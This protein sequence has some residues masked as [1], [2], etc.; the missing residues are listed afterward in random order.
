MAKIHTRYDFSLVQFRYRPTILKRQK[1]HYRT[2]EKILEKNCKIKC[3][4]SK[5]FDIYSMETTF[6]FF[7]L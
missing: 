1:R 6:F 4:S 5:I 7:V 2:D 3:F